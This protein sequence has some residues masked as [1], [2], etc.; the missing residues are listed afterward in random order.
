MSCFRIALYKSRHSAAMRNCD[1]LILA[2][3]R[4]ITKLEAHEDS[5]MKPVAPDSICYKCEYRALTAELTCLKGQE[6]SVSKNTCRNF[7]ENSED[8][9]G[10]ALLTQ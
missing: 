5:S 2:S 8:E 3:Q 1:R 7:S 9:G 10:F 4:A 6:P